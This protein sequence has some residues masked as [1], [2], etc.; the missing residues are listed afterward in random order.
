MD[1]KLGILILLNMAPPQKLVL[2]PGAII[3][4]NTVFQ[5]Y[6]EFTQMTL[7]LCI[8]A[9]ADPGRFSQVKSLVR[10]NVLANCHS[11]L[12]CKNMSGILFKYLIFYFR[13]VSNW[14]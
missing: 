5:V 6:V 12:G 7:N 11:Q 13:Y 9:V 1:V 10:R 4:G 3:R 8:W 14:E 2:A